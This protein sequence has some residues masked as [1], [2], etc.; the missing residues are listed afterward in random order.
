MH[1]AEFQRT[2]LNFRS[3][4]SSQQKVQGEKVLSYPGVLLHAHSRAMIFAIRS[5]A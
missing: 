2:R 5:E 4:H 1:K 3:I